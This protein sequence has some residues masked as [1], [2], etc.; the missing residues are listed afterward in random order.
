[1]LARR[2]VL[3]LLLVC[4]LAGP[5][6]AAAEPGEALDILV[7]GASGDVGSRLVN[8][9]VR[10]SHSV[11]AVTR[12]RDKLTPGRP[13]VTVVEGDLL[14]ATSVRSLLPGQDVV[15]LAVRGAVGGSRDPA[16]TIHVLG[17]RQLVDGIRALP[18]P[19]PRLLIVGGAGSLEVRPGVTY[20]DSVPRLF[21]LFVSRELRQEIAGHK[22]ALA[23]LDG[24][25][26][27]EWTYISPPK[28]L[29]PG[30]RTGQ[31]RL[32]GPQMI[33]DSDGRSRISLPDFAVA[34]LDLAEA[35][36]H[37]HEHLSVVGE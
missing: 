4:C 18:A 21:Y 37:A 33:F 27:V 17:I 7:Y 29:R 28:Q 14:D 31:Y 34:V 35:G 16:Q 20:A 3:G 8:E 15:L 9:A 22:L 2:G 13:H 11:T 1:V 12:H 24:V 19:R 5:F 10:R 25:E 32:G 36:G 26:D 30:L 6:A 23:W